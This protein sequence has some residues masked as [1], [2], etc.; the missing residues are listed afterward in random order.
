MVRAAQQ[1]Q[2]AFLV[3]LTRTAQGQRPRLQFAFKLGRI[4]AALEQVAPRQFVDH[5]GVLQQITGGPLGRA[6]QT[7]QA[8]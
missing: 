1:V 7:Q 4:K 8:F 3:V 5:A 6:Q 2:E